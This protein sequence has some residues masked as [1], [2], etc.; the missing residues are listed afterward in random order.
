LFGGAVLTS[1]P[2]YEKL[3]PFLKFIIKSMKKS[4]IEKLGHEDFRNWEKIKIWTVD[5]AKKIN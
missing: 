1:G 5:I 4:V 2:D 3:N